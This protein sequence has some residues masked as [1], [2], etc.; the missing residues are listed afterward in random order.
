M[1]FEH[2]KSCL[3]N[4]NPRIQ[5]ILGGS[6]TSS[7][8]FYQKQTSWI[9][10]NA[11]LP[12]DQRFIQSANGGTAHKAKKS[13]HVIAKRIAYFSSLPPPHNKAELVHQA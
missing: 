3:L 9:W 11:P 8:L 10:K 13:V 2:Q 7:R 1:S 5:L 4:K 6:S 12:E